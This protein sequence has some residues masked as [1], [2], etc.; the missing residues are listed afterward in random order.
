MSL[1]GQSG[2]N[3]LKQP[4]NYTHCHERGDIGAT[5]K[6]KTFEDSSIRWFI[7]LSVAAAQNGVAVFAVYSS[8]TDRLSDGA[9]LGGVF[10]TQANLVIFAV[11]VIWSISL[12]VKSS[13]KAEWHA[14]LKP[15]GAVVFSSIT[16]IIIG[17]NAALVCTV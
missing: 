14:G 16:A 12:S 1:T 10:G 6:L 2:R 5:T 8:S 17:V 11:L 13:K 15:L 7:A 9:C 4:E 3:L